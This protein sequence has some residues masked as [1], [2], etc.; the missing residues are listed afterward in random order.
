MV[1]EILPTVQGRLPEELLLKPGSLVPLPCLDLVGLNGFVLLVEKK[2]T[3][4]FH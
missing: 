2:R 1:T 3:F 4:F